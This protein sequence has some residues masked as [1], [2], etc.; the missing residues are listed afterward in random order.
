MRRA[1]ANS[2][3]PKVDAADRNF[4]LFADFVFARIGIAIAKRAAHTLREFD[5][6]TRLF[7]DD[8]SF[9]DVS[10]TQE[11]RMIAPGIRECAF[12]RNGDFLAA[13]IDA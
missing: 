5:R 10:L 6:E 2:A 13:F 8:R 3:I 9:D 4:D 1:Q 11:I 7:R 12:A